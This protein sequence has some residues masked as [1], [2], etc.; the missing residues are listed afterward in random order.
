MAESIVTIFDP[1]SMIKYGGLMILLIVVYA[2]TGLFFC[3]FLPGGALLFT[4]GVLLVTGDLHHN[5]ILLTSSLIMAAFCGNITGYWF[6]KK[7]GML[8]FKKKD[9]AFFKHEHIV[10]AETFYKKY[11]G[12]ALTAGYFLP[13]IRTFGP[14]VS[15]VVKLNINQFLLHSFIGAVLWISSMIFSGYLLGSIP[16]LKDYLLY[17]IIAIIIAVTIP[18]ALRIVREFKKLKK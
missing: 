5:L 4:A 6:G 14:I 10:M 1:A 8:L 16:F 12:L 7:A 2:Q 9:S 13:V 17:I 15:G 11:G 18:V 3:F